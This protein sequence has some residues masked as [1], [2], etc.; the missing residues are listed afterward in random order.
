M[1]DRS[2]EIPGRA[3]GLPMLQHVFKISHPAGWR[4]TAFSLPDIRR[5][6]AAL[7]KA[8][9]QAHPLGASLRW[10]VRRLIEEIAGFPS[11]AHHADAA[12][13]VRA[14]V[15]GVLLEA[16]SPVAATAGCAKGICERGGGLSSGAHS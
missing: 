4:Q 12:L 14:L 16:R 7:R 15:D 13:A 5:L 6:L 10:V 2:I 11:K 3:I 1:N 8:S 9:R